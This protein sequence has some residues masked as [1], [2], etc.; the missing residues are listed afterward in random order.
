MD[1]TPRDLYRLLIEIALAPNPQ[2]AIGRLQTVMWGAEA[3]SLG[4]NDE[5]LRELAYD[6]DFFV[7]DPRWR[8][9]DPSY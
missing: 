5:L 2:P 6:L 3:D 4:A 9:E 8:A 7:P 1:M